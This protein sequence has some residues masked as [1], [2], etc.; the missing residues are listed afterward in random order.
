MEELSIV[1]VSDLVEIFN[2]IKSLRNELKQFKEQEE[3]NTAFSIEQV[4]KRL[5]LHYTSV[6]SL[7]IKKKIF[8]KY[9]NETHG[10]C[11]IPLWALKEYLAKEP[12]K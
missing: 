6:R 9:L 7:V 5:N 4:A 10:K 8:A 12:K 11:I 1:K 3:D 2:E